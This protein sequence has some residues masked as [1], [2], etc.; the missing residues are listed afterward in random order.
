MS[1]EAIG[2]LAVT[3]ETIIRIFKTTVLAWVI[4]S[5]PE[6][7]GYRVPILQVF[8]L[9]ICLFAAWLLKAGVLAAVGFEDVPAA[10]DYTFTGVLLTGG[11]MLYHE[12]VDLVIAGKDGLRNWREWFARWRDSFEEVEL[13][14]GQPPGAGTGLG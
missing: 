4:G 1:V 3:I 6:V 8:A 5:F 9:V 7:E 13:V 10:I 12:A 2:A 11:E 14:E